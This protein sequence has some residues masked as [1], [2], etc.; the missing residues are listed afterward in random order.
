M[1]FKT[2]EKQEIQIKEWQE[3]V[4]EVYGEYGTYEYRF[5]GQN[6]CSYHY[7]FAFVLYRRKCQGIV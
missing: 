7:F 5:T 6:I 3:H 1:E 2:T 4:K